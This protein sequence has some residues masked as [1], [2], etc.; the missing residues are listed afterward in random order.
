MRIQILKLSLARVD[1]VR[2]MGCCN[3]IES[4]MRWQQ[5]AP[6]GGGGRRKTASKPN[7]HR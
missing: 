6:K 3:P 7:L 4:A 1:T 5:V 2:C